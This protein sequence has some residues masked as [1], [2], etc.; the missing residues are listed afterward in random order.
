[1]KRSLAALFLTTTLPVH[2]AEV[3]VIHG[4]N[5]AAAVFIAGPIGSNDADQFMAKVGMLGGKTSVVLSGPGGDL[6][7]GIQIGEFVRLRGW[8]TLVIDQC[9]SACALIWLAGTQ[10]IMTSSARVGF[11]AASV[12]G[13]ERGVANAIV[14]AYLNRL[15]YR[16]ETV[17]F[18]TQASP[19]EITLL[20][21]DIASKVGIDVVVRDPTPTTEQPTFRPQQQASSP[22]YDPKSLEIQAQNEASFVISYLYAHKS[23]DAQTF[24]DVYWDNV[25]SYGKMSTKASVLADKQAYF[26]RWPTRSYKINVAQPV[27][28]ISNGTQI[29]ECTVTGTVEFA[30]SSASKKST[31]TA[32]FQ[33]VLRPW[34]LGS[35]NFSAGNQVGLRIASE[36]GKVLSRQITDVSKGS[37]TD[38][39]LCRKYPWVCPPA[40]K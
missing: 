11:H 16:Y 27:K 6:L 14:G 17:V 3:Q 18:V 12:D 28:C 36:N 5:G 39:E 37:L 40:N 29:T 23:N 25:Q 30:V 24:Q 21:P 31:G 32:E 13:Q 35:W 22:K 7:A 1:M 10:R 19:T 9:S 4:D 20:T 26:Q 33:Y 38:D 34:P 8:S 15:G 2:A